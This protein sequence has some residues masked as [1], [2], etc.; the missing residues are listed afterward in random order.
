MISGEAI[1]K[2]I[3]LE[4]TYD[5]IDNSIDNLWSVL[6]TTGYLT[7]V[8]KTERGIYKL[9]IPNKEVKEV[10]T[11]QIQEWFTQKVLQD[12]EPLKVFLKAFLDGDAETVEQ[13][14]TKILGNTI[15]IFD[16]KARSEE[17]EIFY[18]G[19]VLGLLRCESEWLI[20]SNIESG[21][22]LV[23]ILIETEDPDAGIIIELKYAQTFQ[24]LSKACENAMRQIRE[25]R[26]DERLR[27]E[28]RN[29]ILAYGIAFCKKKCKVVVERL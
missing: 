13:Q 21:D 23:D 19:I 16:T 24:G 4:L 28:G 18:H 27:N 26:Y 10:Y 2:A 1:E 7:Q 11:L 5:E 3:R 17:K 12:T 29:D 8:G 15:S 25:R 6:F 20:Q 22:G 9:I 14:L